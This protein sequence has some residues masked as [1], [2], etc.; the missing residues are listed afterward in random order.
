MADTRLAVANEIA[1]A[2]IANFVFG[3]TNRESRRALNKLTEE[4]MHT[5][6]LYSTATYKEA[7]VGVSSGIRR[8]PRGKAGETYHADAEIRVNQQDGTSTAEKLEILDQRS[9]P[10][11]LKDHDVRQK[12]CSY[13][14]NSIGINYSASRVEKDREWID[15]HGELNEQ[16][17]IRIWNEAINDLLYGVRA[18]NSFPAHAYQQEL[19]DAIVARYQAG[20]VDQLLAAIM[21]SGKCFISYEIIR[22]MKFGKVLILTGKTGVNEGWGELLPHGNDP[23]INYTKWVYHNYND[24]KKSRFLCMAE[25]T[26][27]MFGSLQYFAKHIDAYVNK[28]TAMP[29]LVHD[30]LNTEW[31][32]VIFDEQHW[33]NQTEDTQD[34]LTRLQWKYKLE[35]SGTAY[36]TLIQGRYTPEDVH[37][38]DYVDE[39]NRRLNGTSGEQTALEF[40]P[41][42]NYAL[43]NI[44]PKIKN[45][46]SEDGFSFA[47]LMAIIKGQK[48]FKNVQHVSDFLNFVKSR[49]YGNQYTGDMSKFAPYV[50]RINRHTLWVLPNS[51]PSAEALSV[52]LENHPYFKGYKIIKGFGNNTKSIDDAK[53]IIN[54][55]D[56]GKYEGKTKGTI[57]LTLGRWLE[58]TTVPE[59]WCAHQMNDDKSAAD[60]FQGS[61]RTKSEYKKEER[62]K[63]DKRHVLVYDYNP[64]RFIQVVYAT[65]IDSNKRKA[66]QTA[67]DLIRQWKEV[68]DVFDYDGNTFNAITGDVIA[69]RA[70]QDIKLKMELFNSV[71]VDSS[72]V[73]VALQAVMVNKTRTTMWQATTGVN[74]QG[75]AVTANQQTVS[76]S[77]VTPTP[78]QPTT[79]DQVRE[80][81]EKF[82]QAL[83]KISNVVHSTYIKDEQIGSFD[84]ICNYPDSNFILQQTGLTTAEWTMWR[85]SGAI[86]DISQIDHRIDALKESIDI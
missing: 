81:I 83:C 82:K 75:I 66:G 65:N 59:W 29:Q 77:K 67:S 41:D 18:A 21:R 70:N 37:S 11:C 62:L 63:A 86:N 46:L 39:Q 64:E 76:G 42:I 14:S 72:K 52:L 12:I 55:V 45:I 15:F 80:T 2:K 71:A 32:L 58:G 4:K 56:A 54:N 20:A 79:P 22:A 84:D 47:K 38:F 24:L 33:G 57:T 25:E 34:L 85:N 8:P 35:L 16:D 23:H 49:V 27:V 31:D 28:G 51:V 10:L 48:T 40:R 60:Y 61:F 17:M 5:Q 3:N 26:D 68:S 13:T 53:D 74:S 7:T 44:D 78:S 50:D 73:N 6:Y 1:D 19:I 36:K 43:I 30:I 69:E 9:V